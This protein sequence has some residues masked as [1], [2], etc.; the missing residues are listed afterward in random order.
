MRA[1]LVSTYDSHGGAA[2]AAFRLFAALNREVKMGSLLVK[3]KKSQ[4]PDI[5]PVPPKQWNYLQKKRYHALNLMM[6]FL[7]K[8]S[9]SPQGFSIPPE[10]FLSAD[11]TGAVAAF[12]PD[13]VHLH[14]I[15]NDFLSINDLTRIRQPLVWTLHDSWPFTGGCHVPGTCS[16]YQHSCGRCPY[17]DEQNENDLS[18]QIYL[19]KKASYAEKNI[20]VVAPSHW[21]ANCARSS[22]LF[23]GFRIEVIPNGLD[24]AIYRPVDQQFARQILGLPKDRSVILFGGMS[25]TVDPNK[26]FNILL[27]ALAGSSCSDWMKSASLV[28][29]GANECQQTGHNPIPVRFLGTLTDDISLV[30][31]YSAAD[32]M[33]VPS[34]QEAFGQTASEALACGIPVV[35]F[36]TSGLVDIV[37]HQINGYL[38]TSYDPADLLHGIKYVLNRER[39]S[40]LKYNARKKATEV[41]S[42]ATVA[43]KYQKLYQELASETNPLSPRYKK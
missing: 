42:I 21:L 41:F 5:F 40:Q 24:T 18:H 8:K 13:V 17:L 36:K 1:L 32:V 43:A 15:C 7:R 19:Q 16:R 30:L 31:A 33:V 34:L 29:F 37:D 22:S 2:R 38:A 28:V 20:T 35:C 27:E 4:H 23:E 12:Q 11:L 3:T 14:W 9:V 26:G 10:D 6:R 25:S 39:A